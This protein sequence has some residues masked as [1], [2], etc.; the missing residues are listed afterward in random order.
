MDENISA[1]APIELLTLLPEQPSEY[2]LVIVD[3]E[4]HIVNWFAIQIPL[5]GA[6]G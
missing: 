5:A 1:M 3:P 4:K 6:R 2:A